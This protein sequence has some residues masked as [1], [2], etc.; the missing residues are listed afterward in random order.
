[1]KLSFDDGTLIITPET[2]A[3]K[4]EIERLTGGF[5]DEPDCRGNREAKNQ[6]GHDV[7]LSEDGISVEFGI[8]DAWW[9]Y[10]D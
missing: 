6:Y 4:A 1:M 2:E 5:Q 9:N 7:T 10:D 8:K 3:D